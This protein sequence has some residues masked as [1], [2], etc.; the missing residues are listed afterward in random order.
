MKLTSQELSEIGGFLSGLD[1]TQEAEWMKK[2][3]QHGQISTYDHVMSV[4]HLSFYLNRR[5]HLGAAE[6]ELVRGAFLHDFY[7][8]DWH[9]NG[10][11][12][13]LH[14]Y[15]HPAIALK[16]ALQRYEL[17]PVEQNIIKSHMWPLTLFSVPRYRASVIVCLADKICS[18]YEVVVRKRPL[19][20]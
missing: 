2:C 7:L 4:V 1:S 20:C 19:Q 13:R 12:G 16:N 9:E 5:F 17:T 8:Y 11:F 14:G 10:Y 6:S 3:I 15:H 18:A